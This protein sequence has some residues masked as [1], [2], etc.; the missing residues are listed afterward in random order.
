MG[1]AL[2]DA[3]AGARLALASLVAASVAGCLTLLAPTLLLAAGDSRATLCLVVVTLALAALVRL[4]ENGALL[5][6]RVAAVV[7]SARAE[8][9]P[10][11]TGR[12][13]D[14]AHQPLRPRA[15]GL[16]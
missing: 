3:R 12:I 2:D 10:V 6:S 14:P 5:G 13:T 4:G 1:E 15:P 9:P 8:A 11:L 16:A 7:S